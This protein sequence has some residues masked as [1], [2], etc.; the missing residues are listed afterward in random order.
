MRRSLHL[1]PVSHHKRTDKTIWC[2]KEAKELVGP[3]SEDILFVHAVLGCDTTSC[4]FGLGKALAVSKFRNDVTFRKQ[5]KFF[6]KSQQMVDRISESGEKALVAFS[7]GVTEMKDL[8]ELRFQAF[9]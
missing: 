1:S 8:H 6:I 4:R 2:I 5:A 9:L 3:S 7:G